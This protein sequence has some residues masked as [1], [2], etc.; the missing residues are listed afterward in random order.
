MATLFPQGILFDGILYRIIPGGYAVIGQSSFPP[1]PPI[2]HCYLMFAHT[3]LM[4]SLPVP[5]LSSLISDLPLHVSIY[6][7]CSLCHSYHDSVLQHTMVC[8]FPFRC[9]GADGGRHSHRF[10]CGNLLRADRSDLSHP[11]HDGRR[12]PGQHGCAGSATV[13]VR[14]HHPGQEAALSPRAGLRPHK[15]RRHCKYQCRGSTYDKTAWLTAQ[16][17]SLTLAC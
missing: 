2:H 5:I 7:L 13:T 14:L 15:V 9:G 16:P 11:S 10:H 4:M 1:P 3:V 17:G 12:H 8:P 6:S